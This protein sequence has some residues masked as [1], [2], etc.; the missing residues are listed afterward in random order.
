MEGLCSRMEDLDLDHQD[1]DSACARGD[2]AAVAA[3]AAG[4]AAVQ[5]CHVRSAVRSDDPETCWIAAA[6][7]RSTPEEVM[8]LAIEEGSERVLERL[9][10][11]K[12]CPVRKQHVLLA[13]EY[14]REA[15]LRPLFRDGVMRGSLEPCEQGC[16]ERECMLACVRHGRF[17]IFRALLHEWGFPAGEEVAREARRA[18]RA[19]ILGLLGYYLEYP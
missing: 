10:D 13:I 18:R 15:M 2:A 1:L 14:G 12:A 3:R 16:L 7:A 6:A 19:G 5:G 17:E 4:G 9:L 8:R 11:E